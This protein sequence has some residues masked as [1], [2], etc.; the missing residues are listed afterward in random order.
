MDEQCVEKNQFNN[1]LLVKMIL[2]VDEFLKNQFD[3]YLLVEMVFHMDEF[4]IIFFPVY[5]H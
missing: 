2:C 5:Y 3:N 1:H 4:F